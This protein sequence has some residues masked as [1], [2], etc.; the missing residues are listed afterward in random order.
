MP[1]HASQPDDKRIGNYHPIFSVAR[2]VGSSASVL[3]AY[4]FGVSAF[5]ASAFGAS[6]FDA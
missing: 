6:A 2:F 5:G 3:G 1:P 4:P